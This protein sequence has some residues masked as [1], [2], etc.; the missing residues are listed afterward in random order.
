M[1]D[2][3]KY[4]ADDDIVFEVTPKWKCWLARIFGKRLETTSNCTAYKW[5]GVIYITRWD[6][7]TI[8]NIYENPELLGE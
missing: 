3:I 2:K 4:I 1:Q 7:Q 5:R 6:N 8:G